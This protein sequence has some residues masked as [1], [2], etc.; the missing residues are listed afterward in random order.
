M[1]PSQVPTSPNPP[2]ILR[3]PELQKALRTIEKYG[4]WLGVTGVARVLADE[5]LGEQPSIA[6]N[7]D[8]WIKNV[9]R[10]E[11]GRM[12]L[13]YDAEYVAKARREGKAS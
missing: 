9:D 13:R 11:C 5:G 4:G 6:A 2:K 7:I 1:E 8:W 12:F 10:I 3:P